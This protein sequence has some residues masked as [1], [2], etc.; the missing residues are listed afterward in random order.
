MSL[1]GAIAQDSQVQ[2]G[3]LAELGTLRLNCSSRIKRLAVTSM[4]IT[5]NGIIQAGHQVASGRAK[6]NRYSDSTIKMQKPF[7]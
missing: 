5:I 3:V 4:R 2:Y 1:G 7:F 6:Q